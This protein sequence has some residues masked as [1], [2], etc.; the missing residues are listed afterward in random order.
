MATDDRIISVQEWF[1][2][3]MPLDTTFTLIR[4]SKRLDIPESAIDMKAMMEQEADILAVVILSSV[5]GYAE[6]IG[7]SPAVEEFRPLFFQDEYYTGDYNGIPVVFHFDYNR[8]I[9]G[10]AV[11]VTMKAKDKK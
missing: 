10:C 4:E 5:K 2:R 8:N 11:N 3:G 6:D 9:L 1:K 7:A